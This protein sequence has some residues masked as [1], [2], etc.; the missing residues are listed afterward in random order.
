MQWSTWSVLSLLHT[1]LFRDIIKTAVFRYWR[2]VFDNMTRQV[3]ATS[4]PIEIGGYMES[5]LKP[6]TYPNLLLE[7]LD[8]DM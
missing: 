2:R 5:F 6:Q 7:S 8:L 1:Y 3:P 4:Q